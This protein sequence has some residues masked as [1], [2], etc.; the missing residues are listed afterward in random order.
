MLRKTRK[1]FTYANVAA[2][3][4]LLFSMSGGALAASH[5]LINSTKQ[6]NPSVLKALKGAKGKTGATGPQGP[7]G[8]PGQQGAPGNNGLEGKEGAAGAGV[9]AYAFMNR[10][11]S[12]NGGGSLVETHNF[13]SAYTKPDEDEGVYCLTPSGDATAAK[14]PIAMVTP[15][16]SYSAEKTT[17]LFAYP[18]F[19][20]PDC[21][22]GQ[23][24]VATYAPAGKLSN[25]VA[26]YIMVAG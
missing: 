23:Y 11:G 10:R 4:A 24:E 19:G 16:Y 25:K 14:D 6:I 12:T 22:A 21:G 1:R 5:Y 18:V 2:T 20:A 8:W 15:E 9:V 26:F 17:E 7:Q 3:L 13:A